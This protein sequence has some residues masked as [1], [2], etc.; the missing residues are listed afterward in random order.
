MTTASERI[1]YLGMNLTTKVKDLNT[2]NHKMWVKTL[3]K[4]L[5]A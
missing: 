4:A 2:E 5:R 3:Y 1:K